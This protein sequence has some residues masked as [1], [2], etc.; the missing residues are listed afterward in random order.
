MGEGER[1]TKILRVFPSV[2][3]LWFLDALQ[4]GGCGRAML[5]IDN[6]INIKQTFVMGGNLIGQNHQVILSDQ[7]NCGRYWMTEWQ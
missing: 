7:G 3:S 2:F 1:I 6:S 5:I 4:S